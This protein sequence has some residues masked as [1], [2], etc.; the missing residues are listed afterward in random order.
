[1]YIH[2][3]GIKYLW[4]EEGKKWGGGSERW[5]VHKYEQGMMIY[6]NENATKEPIILY[7]N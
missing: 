7:N 2:V 3:Y 1:M 6:G 4:R 5:T